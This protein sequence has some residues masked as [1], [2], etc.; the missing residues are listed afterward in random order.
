MD[1]EY[2]GFQRSVRNILKFCEENPDFKKRICGVVA[3]L[4]KV[5][6]QYEV[7]IETALGASLQHIVTEDE[8]DAKYI[9]ELLKKKNWGRATFLPITAVKGRSSLKFRKEGFGNGRMPW[10]RIGINRFR[11]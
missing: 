11:A 8:E 4:I 6:K 9:I 2:E 5:P 3:E 7:A 1:R 10:D